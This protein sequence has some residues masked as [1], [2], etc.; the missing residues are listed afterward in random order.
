MTEI[1]AY[2]CDY[3][4]K[5]SKSKS[6]IKKHEPECFHNPIVRACV[7]CG[8]Y[9]QKHYMV[10]MR[11]AFSYTDVYSCRPICKAGKIISDLKNGKLTTSLCSNCECWI[12]KEG[13]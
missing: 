11:P 1:V 7:T 10:E 3:C 2:Q 9:F 13:E 6:V 12:E 4:K 5:Y 8:N